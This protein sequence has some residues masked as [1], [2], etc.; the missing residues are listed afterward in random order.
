MPALTDEWIEEQLELCEKAMQAPW[1]DGF[2]DESGHIGDYRG[3]WIVQ[4]GTDEIVIW[5]GSHDG[6]PV[7]VLKQENVDLI[8][9]AREG[10]PLVL[11]ALQ[12]LRKQVRQFLESHSVQYDEAGYWIVGDSALNALD[13]AMEI[14]DASTD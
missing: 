9:A 1:R 11:N 7:G 8:T 2:D 14:A 13:R 6:I 4:E 12:S 5:G 10:Y 3:A